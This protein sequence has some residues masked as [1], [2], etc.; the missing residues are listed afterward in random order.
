MAIP[1]RSRAMPSQEKFQ[2]WIDLLGALLA[3]SS[4]ATFDELAA[5]VPEYALKR[6]EIASASPAQKKTLEESL[7][8]TFE[9]DKQELKT[10]GV[11]L[12]ALADDDGNPGGAYR[13]VR[14]NFYLPYL[15]LA[16]PGAA[17]AAV[18]KVDKFGYRKLATLSFEPDELTAVVDAAVLVRRLGDPLLAA[19]ASSALRKLAVD[20]PVDATAMSAR[21]EPAAADG[22]PIVLMPRAR[23]STETFELLGHALRARK[24]V[25]FH[26]H[27]FSDDAVATREVEP[28]GLFFLHGHWYLAARDTTIA[29]VRNF[30]LNRITRVA[31]NTK[32]ALSADFDVPASFRLRTHADS[33]QAWELGDEDVIAVT[34]EFSGESGATL[35]AA[36]LGKPVDGNARQ[37]TFDVRRVDPFVRWALSLLGEMRVVSPA[38]VVERFENEVAATRAL[39][40]HDAV[41]FDPALVQA[42]VPIPMNSGSTHWQPKGAAAQLQ[43]ILQVIPRLAD[44]S[45]HSLIEVAQQ[46]GTDA[47]TITRDLDSLVQRFAAPA[48]HVEGVQLY[49]ES[50]RVSV[51]SNHF[52][53]PMRLTVPELCALELG[54]AMLRH[55]LA[56]NEHAVLDSARKRLRTMILQLGSD[57]I[58]EGVHHASIGNAGNVHSLGVLRDALA[59][60]RRVRLTYRR[61][62]RVTSESRDIC[63]YALVAA[64][65]M[66]YVVAHC[67]REQAVRVFRMDRVESAELLRDTFERPADFRVDDVVS[68]GRVFQGEHAETLVIRFSPQI[69][70]WIAEREGVQPAADGAL[71]LAYP[72]ADSAWALRFV[73][74]YGAEAEALAPPTIRR[75]LRDQLRAPARAL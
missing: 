64:N 4:P 27:T 7:K 36:Q 68:D 16:L 52:L 48:G 1:C 57:R 51:V 23:A 46:T 14:E 40:Q 44:G 69:A 24:R 71:V 45:E 53:R 49:L 32:N 70:R 20:L 67:L 18:K 12:E 75:L 15:C 11:P 66:L 42:P 38:S 10:F 65:G 34:V 56:P 31:V 37:R 43:R 26:Y 21:T 30:R 62:G 6:A 72:L 33:R 58:P 73:L 39:Y 63:P 9:R 47:A 50:D 35:A 74:Q 61:S 55:Q 54:L 29:E 2:R 8:R 28:Y 59:G 13:L 22:T 25:T 41:T 5:A 19:D 17:T 3:R 60:Q